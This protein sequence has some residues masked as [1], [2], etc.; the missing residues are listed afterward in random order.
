MTIRVAGFNG[1]PFSANYGTL[2][3]SRSVDGTVPAEYEAR[4][5]TDP[6]AADSVSATV[7]KTSEDSKELRVQIIDNGMVVKESSTTEDYGAAYLRWSPNERPSGGT[8]ALSTEK[9]REESRPR[10]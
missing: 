1:E 5:R 2:D 9:T 7:W 8:T 6:R 3:S 10:P 4:V